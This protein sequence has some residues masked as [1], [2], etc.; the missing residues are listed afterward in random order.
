MST[1]TCHQSTI[2]RS[3]NLWLRANC[4][5]TC[6]SVPSR[7]ELRQPIAD[8]PRGTCH[9]SN[10]DKSLTH[11]SLQDCTNMQACS[12]TCRFDMANSQH[13]APYREG[14]ALQLQAAILGRCVQ[15]SAGG[16]CHRQSLPNRKQQLQLLFARAL[17]VGSE[18]IF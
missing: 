16:Y 14:Q 15:M 4:T 10:S 5:E 3:Q 2:D 18:R 6:D 11:N 1:G 8:V 12:F 17:S 13:K 9:R 7:P